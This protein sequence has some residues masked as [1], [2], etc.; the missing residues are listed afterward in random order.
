MMRIVISK[1]HVTLPQVSLLGNVFQRLISTPKKACSL[2]CINDYAG[3]TC[4]GYTK[5]EV[6][7]CTSF[8][9]HKPKF[10]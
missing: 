7:L 3:I 5:Q 1:R 6:Y 2:K 9:I 8:L 10:A 4:P